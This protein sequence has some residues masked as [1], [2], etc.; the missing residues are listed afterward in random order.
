MAQET[1][2]RVTGLDIHQAGVDAANTQAEA[3]GLADR[4]LR[5]RRHPEAALFGDATFDA[6]TC[7]DS[8][9]HLYERERVLRE[10]HR[11]LRSDARMLFTDPITV[12][13]PIRREE[14]IVR[15]GS[16]GSS[17]SR[18]RAWT[19]SFFEMDSWTSVSRTSPRTW[20]T[21]HRAGGLP[22]SS[23]ATSSTESSAAESAAFQRFLEVVAALARERRLS[24]LAFVAAKP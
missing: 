3:L 5:S 23:T 8:F 21:S 12:T 16:M 7:I 20:T 10:W 1:G 4:A 19:S 17:S 2:C 14:M 13:G 6:L 11:V 22:A 15:S 9:N 24:R 18:R